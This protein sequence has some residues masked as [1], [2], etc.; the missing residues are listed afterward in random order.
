M[1]AEAVYI[2]LSSSVRFAIYP[3]GLD[4]PRILVE[5][6]AQAL[7]TLFGADHF[8]ESHV[9]ACCL[10]FHRIQQVAVRHHQSNPLEA[11]MLEAKDF[12]D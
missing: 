8:P 12:N 7:E 9:A 11:V 1:V 4:G 5:I 10:H 2:G 3:E 6:S